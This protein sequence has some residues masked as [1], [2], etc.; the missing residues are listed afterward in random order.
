MQHVSVCIREKD[1][2]IQKQTDTGTADSW[3]VLVFRSSKVKS[4]LSGASLGC[5]LLAV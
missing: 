3:I 1:R 2:D 5:S 4:N